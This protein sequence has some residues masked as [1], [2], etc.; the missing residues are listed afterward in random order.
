M[1][2]SFHKLGFWGFP[3]VN[4]GE[5]YV[6]IRI[7]AHHF[8]SPHVFSRPPDVT[9]SSRLLFSEGTFQTRPPSSTATASYSV[10]TL[11]LSRIPNTDPITKPSMGGGRTQPSTKNPK[12]HRTDS[13]NPKAPNKS[14]AE[15]S[16]RVERLGLWAPQG[17]GLRV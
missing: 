9:P 17:L 6:G 12:R 7:G 10:I 14:P 2:G 5:Y 13:W 3:I 4:E 1:R 16:T 11:Q 15:A 8:G